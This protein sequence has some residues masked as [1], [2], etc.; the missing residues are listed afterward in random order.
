MSKNYQRG[1]AFAVAC[2]SLTYYAFAKYLPKS[3]FPFIGKFSQWLRK[4]CCQHLFSQC[5]IGLNVEQGAYFGNGKDVCAGDYV[6]L[7]KDFCMHGRLLKAQGQLLMGEQVMFLGA[8][9]IFDNTSEPIALQGVKNKTPLDIGYD[10]WIG[11]RTTV[12]SGCKKI[13]KGA[14]IAACSVVTHDVPDYA[15]VAGN[16]AKVIKY[17]K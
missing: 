14:V 3:T 7:G 15:V 16:P 9:H 12:L 2:Y 1:G 13:G 5:G 11:A 8:D 17:R 6:R 10:V 4:Q